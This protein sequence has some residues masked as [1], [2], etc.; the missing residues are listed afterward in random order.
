MLPP[1]VVSIWFLLLQFLCFV[2]LFQ[3]SGC[4]GKSD[5]LRLENRNFETEV[6]QE[7]NLVFTFDKRLVPDSLL[8][9]W[10]TIPYLTFTPKIEGKF[11]WTAPDELVF[12]PAQALAPSTDYT[13]ELTS[14]LV[15]HSSVALKIPAGQEVK[16]HTP[17]LHL[18]SAKAYW[19]QNENNPTQLEANLLFDFNYPVPF[20]KLRDKLKVFNGPQELPIELVSSTRDNISIKVKGLDQTPGAGELPVRVV[21]DKGLSTPGSTYQ[22]PAPLQQTVVVPGRD[23]MQIMEVVTVQEEGQDK[24]YVLTTQP[25]VNPDLNALVSLNP[26]REYNL[27]RLE[28]GL[29]ISGNFATNQ[30]YKLAISGDLS[31]VVGKSMGKAYEHP[32]TFASQEPTVSFIHQ[33][34]IYLSSQGARNIALNLNQVPRVKV[35]ISKVFE[36]NILR[37]LQEGQTFDGHYDEETEEYYENAYY[38]VNESNGKTIFEREY[39]T[40]RLQK[41]GKNHLL[42][43]DLADLDFDSHFKGLYVITV[44]STEKNWLKD[45]KIVSVSDIGLIAKQGKNEV[46]VFANS[47]RSAQPL[48]EVEVRFISTN[49]QVVHKATTDKDGVARFPDMHKTAAGFKLGLITVRQGD[50][51]NYLPYSQTEVN[52][53]R[54]DVG[55]KRLADL[56]YDAFI[57]GD[58]DLYRPGDT[59]HVNTVVRTPSWKTVSGLPLKVKLLLPNGKEYRSQKGTLNK[60][61][62]YEA[63][64]VLSTSVVTGTYTLEVYSGNDVLLNTRKIG[65]EE[66]MPDRLKVTTVLNKTDFSAG[67]KVSVNLTSQN[68]FG[69]PASGR[70]YEVQLSL[71]KKTFEAP[72]YPDY[73]FELNNARDANLQNSVRQG[74]T[75]AEGKGQET[76]E[77]ND[78]QDIG[79][80]EGSLFTT[81]FDETGRPVNRLNRINVSTQYAFYGLKNFDSYVSTRQEMQ[82]PIIALN[83]QGQPIATKVQVQLVRYTYETVMERRSEDYNYKSQ[84]RESVLLN[85]VLSV[86]KGGTAVKFLPSTSGEYELR[87]MRPGA[88]NYV[89]QEFYAYGWGDTESTSFEVNT[90]GEVDIA[91]DKESYEVGE[92]AKVLFKSPFAGKILVTVEQNKVLSYHYLKTDKKAASLK[93]PIRD[94]HLPTIYISAVALREVKDNQMPLTIAR[95]F[96][97]VQVTKKETKLEVAI[98]APE[99]SRSN[100][101]QPVYIKTAPNAEVTLAV[102]DEGILQL[103]DFQT[104]DPHAFFYQKRAL[105]VQAFDL[106][107]FLFPELRG[108]RSSVGGD[109]YDLEKRINPLT[110]KR[111]KLVSLWSGRLKTNGKGEATVKVKIPEFSGAVR[112]MAVAYKENAFGSGEKIMRVADPVVISTALPRFLSPKDT[113]LVPVTISNTTAKSAPFSSYLSVTGPLKVVGPA[114]VSS[115]SGA[116]AEKQVLYRLVAT[117]AIGQASV[118][119]VVKALGE[120]FSNS[121]EITVRPTA[122]LTQITGAGSLKNGASAQINPTHDFLPSSV[123]SKLVVSSS[124]LAQFTDDI[125]FLLRYPHG[126]LEQ[127]TSTAFPLLY[128]TDLAKSLNQGQKGRR[129]NPTYLV[130]E[131]ITKIEGMQQYDGGFTYWPGGSDTDWWSSAYALHFLLEAQKAGYAVNQQVLNRAQSYLQRMVKAKGT[132][133]YRFYDVSR[134][135][136]KKVIA[137]HE[138]AYSLYVLSL[139]GKPDWSTMNFYKTKPELLSIDARYVLAS[140]YALN[141]G[142]QSSR[143]LLPRSFAGETSVRALD[144]SFYSPLRDMALALNSLLE[145][146]PD[147]PQVPILVRHLSQELRSSRW[148]NTQERAFALLALGKQAKR[149]GGNITAQILQKGKPV[150]SFNGKDLALTSQLKSA[151]ITLQSKGQGTLYYFWETEGISQS[152]SYPQEDNFLQVRKTYFNRDGKEITNRT[153]KQNDLVVVRIAL[154]TLDGRSIPNVAITDLLP[155]GFEIENPRLMTSRE[156]SWLQAM[157]PATPE[158]LDIRDDRINLYTTAQP[159]S[160]Y[161]FYQ[162]RAVSKGDFQMGPVGADAM[163]N[164]EYHS[165]H[166]AGVVKVR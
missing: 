109:G 9:Q 134:K 19:T 155:A 82:V 68:L 56:N 112:I 70:T 140:T 65:V 152:G 60:E 49:N 111:V 42:N 96:K 10:D 69:P 144:G 157:V 150:G 1:K 3:L 76:F 137:A 166:G 67:E 123:S 34:S 118:K 131:A 136:Q 141:G 105:E 108:T 16:F 115:T 128:Y 135:L 129:F 51:F 73:T 142:H 91:L 146:N 127:T 23:Q 45:S 97:P 30:Q 81:V 133:E 86:D 48:P 2:V 74:E 46:L 125:T 53:S 24:I 4:G 110:S 43:L 107:P 50:D 165:Y 93:L 94:E 40:S 92:V 22:T 37:Y 139:A 29:V 27:E 106:Y 161:F 25:I 147:H 20:Q 99:T 98:T 61:G 17:Y 85:T 75:N 88:Y 104:P 7:Q 36:N 8:N 11:K 154:Q 55:G 63:T 132:E 15:A 100:R 149:S 114:T 39:E 38:D 79:L 122:P 163:Y 47:I 160:Q 35:T 32:V 102:V 84:R 64:F 72:K 117:P 143:Q 21:L 77:L 119:V 33:K 83:A 126:C 148:Y 59:V 89:A 44:A 130:Q 78:F 28:N 90:E 153:F 145:A 54:F 6:A 66:F 156:F 151:P 101:L 116:N 87:V 31:G 124:P 164:A 62:A 158:H 57:Y 120:Q 121:T 12:S 13:T 26:G 41:Q 95:G 138:T 52:T 5:E 18:N 113:L 162:V 159:K 103:K 80:L 14:R 71:K 58:R